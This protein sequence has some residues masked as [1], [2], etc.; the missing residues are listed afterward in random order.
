MWLRL[1]NG[2][3]LHQIKYNFY[4]TKGGNKMKYYTF[5]LKHSGEKIA[6]LASS[7]ASAFAKFCIYYNPN[8]RNKGECKITPIAPKGARVIE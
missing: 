2:R 1:Q 5:T 4:S 8:D 3:N 6:L 7:F